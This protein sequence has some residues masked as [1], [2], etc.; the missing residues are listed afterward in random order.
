MADVGLDA[1]VRPDVDRRSLDRSAGKLKERMSEAEKLEPEFIN[2]RGA[3]QKLGGVLTKELKRLP[4]GA[5][6]SSLI[7]SFVGGGG[8]A[9]GG[10]GGGGVGSRRLEE[11]ENDILTL[12][13]QTQ[14]SIL[15]QLKKQGFSEATEE[16]DD[17]SVM[18]T[19]GTLGLGA[20]LAK[21][22]SASG[23]IG[24]GSAI[25]SALPSMEG[26]S[27]GIGGAR[28]GG[29]PAMSGIGFPAIGS[30]LSKELFKM[31]EG[32]QE[33]P[34]SERGGL[35][36]WLADNFSLPE[37]TGEGGGTSGAA[38]IQPL[39]LSEAQDITAP[40]TDA[41][42]NAD[43]PTLSSM[44]DT[45]SIPSI[46]SMLNLDSAPTVDSLLGVEQM[47]SL[48]DIL[49]GRAGQSTTEG[50]G[51]R[52]SSGSGAL[53]RGDGQM[54]RPDQLQAPQSSLQSE[55]A[56]EL[57]SAFE[58]AIDDITQEFNLDLTENIELDFDT[59]KIENS[60]DEAIREVEEDL[61]KLEEQIK[62][63]GLP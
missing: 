19:T 7:G 29:A 34:E 13:L 43:I 20:I 59:R 47:P 23:G 31:G 35:E 60:I 61:K 49:L 30:I 41:I 9:G 50:A 22:L 4:G 42:K 63:G 39:T 36:D 37:G 56:S 18:K 11:R 5:I 58:S 53:T 24:I 2:V 52:R 12:Q 3:A 44:L 1:V 17:G 6:V 14:R 55:L 16:D 26:L 57:S 38:M 45:G 10:G 25:S 40:L 48:T 33:K 21:A 54:V 46:S 27:G 32:A 62:R 8:G 28:G 51:S 15:K